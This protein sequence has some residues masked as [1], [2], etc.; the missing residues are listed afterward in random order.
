MPP[1]GSDE[2]PQQDSAPAAPLRQD[3][4]RKKKNVASVA[5]PPRLIAC[6]SHVLKSQ[7]HCKISPCG[8]HACDWIS[9][10][11]G[12]VAW[13]VPCPGPAEN[14]DGNRSAGRTGRSAKTSNKRSESP[15]LAEPLPGKD[16]EE[17]DNGDA[18]SSRA[19]DQLGN[20]SNGK[21]KQ[22]PPVA[23]RQAANSPVAD[24][25]NKAP[26]KGVATVET[27]NQEFN[28]HQL[29]STS[30]VCKT[31]SLDRHTFLPDNLEASQSG[32]TGSG[33]MPMDPY[34]ETQDNHARPML[35][36]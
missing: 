26:K 6:S 27:H 16:E 24:A 10:V 35:L 28:Q 22:R 7:K 20:E 5:G 13:P 12:F 34:M 30:T 3:G 8:T 25:K 14:D 9:G 18:H 33:E 17:N 21:Q 15:D 31:S 2:S 19:G 1:C 4:R 23:K 36:S 11:L 32:S 29:C